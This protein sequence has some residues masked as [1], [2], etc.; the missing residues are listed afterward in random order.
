M[1]TIA[2]TVLLQKEETNLAKRL[3]RAVMSRIHEELPSQS[4]NVPSGIVTATVCSRS[5][6]LPI[7]GLCNGTLKTEYFAEGTVPTTTCDVHYVGS[8]CQYSGLPAT[9]LCPFRVD[10]VSELPLIED[11][12]LQSGTPGTT[13]VNEDGSISTVAATRTENICPHNAEFFADPNY[14]A[15]INQ[16]RLEIN[17]RN[18][19]AAQAAADAA[20]AAEAA[21]NPAP[22]EEPAPA[23][24]AQ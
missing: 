8:V 14:Q 17:Q 19:A 3:W 15:V 16:Q 6:K 18:A 11:I 2:A 1:T 4:F 23:E 12:S 7:D 10:G 24:A 5:G 9:E 13:V 20:A 21:A 22:A